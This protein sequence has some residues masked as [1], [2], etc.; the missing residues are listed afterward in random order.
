[1]ITFINSNYYAD[2]SVAGAIAD[3]VISKLGAETTLQNLLKS[4]DADMES[5]IMMYIA[6]QWDIDV[7]ELDIQ[8]D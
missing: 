2:R 7:S 4:M 5:D 8:E 3:R 6:Q 1:M